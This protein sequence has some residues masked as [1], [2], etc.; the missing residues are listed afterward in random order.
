MATSSIQ[1]SPA[2][3]MN[4][5]PGAFPSTPASAEAPSPSVVSSQL[6]LS[7]AV[8]QRRAEYTRSRRIKVKVGTWNV[9]SLSGTEKD[10]GGW[11]V[12]GKGVSESLSGLDIKDDGEPRSN[13]HNG[14]P[15]IESVASQEE[16][17]SKKRSTIP[18]NDPGFV[19][20]GDE[21]GLYVLGLQEI[22]DI[23]SVA[24]ALRPY[25]DP[26]PGRKWKQAVA[27]SL[28]HGYQRVAEQQLIGLFLV[29]YA[30]SEIAPTISSVSTTSVGTGLGGYMGNKGAVT[31]RIVLGETTRMVF[32]NCHLTAGVE[33]GNLERR[34][35]DASQI[36]QRTKF[37]PVYDGGGVMEEFGEGI[38]DEDFAFWFGDLNYRL[39]SMP[40]EDV[41]RLL[42]LHTRNEYGAHGAQQ[43]SS[44][45]IENE[46]AKPESLSFSRNQ[47][48]ANRPSENDTSSTH[49][50]IENASDPS[51][52]SSITVLPSQ[53][54]LDPASDPA[55]LQTTLSSLL[56]HDQL[57]SQMRSRKAFHDG[58]REGIIDFL[59]TYKYDVGS[60]GMFDSSEKQRGPSWC[61][62]ILYRTRKDRLEYDQKVRD[63]EM[64]RKKDNEM[65]L[66]G[67]VDAVTD[68]SVLFDY[69]PETDGADNEN[70]AVS[71]QS[72]DP[73]FMTTKA[74]F[75]DK[76]SLDYYKSHQRV[77]SSDHKP[78]DAVFTLDYDAVD[79][80]MKARI[81]QEVARELDRAENEGRPVV[82]IV[83]DH[84]KDTDS[85]HT[86]SSSPKFEGVDFGHVK[87]DQVKT[88]SVTIA[89]TGRV[90]ATV[91]FVDRSIES[92]RPGGVAPPWLKINFDRPPDSKNSN[93][94]A[95]QEHTLQPGDAVNVELTLHVDDLD[96]VRRLGDKV[97]TLE[98]V[99]VLRIHNGRDY[100]LPLRG[101]WLQSAFGRSIEKL[102][103]IPEGG[104]RRWQ[105]QRPDG[106]S[107][108]DEGVKWSAPREVFRLTEAI[109]DLV[110]RA[111]AQWGMTGDADNAPWDKDVGWPFR[112]WLMEGKQRAM[113]KETVR[114]G[115]DS[116]QPFSETFPPEIDSLQRLEA[117]AET[118]VQ[119]LESLE[120]GIV[121]EALWLELEKGMLE[122]EKAKKTLSDEDERMWILDTLSTA[123]AHSVSFTF[124]TFM[125]ARVGNEVAPWNIPLECG[126][127][128]GVPAQVAPRIKRPEVDAA[129]A[130]I[131]ADA[132]IRL[133]AASKGKE[134]KASETRRKHVVEVFLKATL[135]VGS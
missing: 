29:I 108:G 90:P 58:W 125:L 48:A 20:G 103:R 52:A 31:A 128:E 65:K 66:Q 32:V 37:D 76:L 5:T 134:R 106:S 59:P 6:S 56:A 130:G 10:V 131:F 69:D 25:S 119:F 83:V 63:E 16:R 2:S 116:D 45:K 115:L 41:R 123:P 33:K 107:H 114:E 78:L 89:N 100:F 22:V 81:H 26:H 67:V 113:L 34:N 36:L 120:D 127:A 39:E 17:R 8:H 57:H 75:E 84:Q 73:E 121:T 7:Q 49:I 68:E 62:R 44:K 43:P 47:E 110:E 23:S 61:D 9:A 51:V 4:S 38:G 42:M 122:R 71:E 30:S 19:P 50:S 112:G 97:E 24:E 129:Y 98:D 99:L 72:P 88:R 74:G 86:D 102:V 117:V 53:E 46:L 135:D 104:V 14:S 35:W 94:G 133:P 85:T 18:K 55:S 13:G 132:M 40:G 12:D 96:L 70:N 91:G 15:D 118:L 87:Y 101:D 77:L 79:L 80:E 28:P 11:F 3:K 105:H 126:K 60:V 1:T 54:S 82:T 109:E 124:V 111:L 21:I 27:E 64:A 93:P 92:G 95:L